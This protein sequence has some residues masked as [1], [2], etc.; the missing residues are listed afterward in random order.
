MTIFLTKITLVRLKIYNL[1]PLSH[2]HYWSTSNL[3]ISVCSYVE[4]TVK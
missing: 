1:Y 2:Y 4:S 3:G